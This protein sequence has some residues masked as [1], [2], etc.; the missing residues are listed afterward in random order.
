MRGLWRKL[1]HLRRHNELARRLREELDFHTDMKASESGRPVN[2][3]RR[4]VGNSARIMEQAHDV[5]S[6]PALEHVALDLRYAWRALAKSPAF[7]LLAALGTAL[8]VAA[9]TTVLS[10]AS[11][12]LF[13]AVPYRDADRLVVVSDQL[14]NLGFPRFPVTIAN[15][16]D[17]RAQ[18]RVF[19]DVAAFDSRAVT[20]VTSERAERISGMLVSSNFLSLMGGSMEQGRWIT[21]E[22]NHG[23]EDRAVVL[24]YDFW[25]SRFGGEAGVIGKRILIDD[26]SCNVVGVLKQGFRFRLSGE[27]PQAWLP[28]NLDPDPA[29]L[30]GNFRL[31]ARLARGVS[32][33][34]ASAQ[35]RVIATVLQRRYRTGMG[36]H[37]EDGGYGIA[38]VPV[39]G[40]LYGTARPTMY[41]SAIA[42]GILLLLGFANTAVLW[43]GRAS[44][45]RQEA[46]VRLALGASRWRV[47]QQ[48]VIEALMPAMTGGVLAL[49]LTLVAL[50]VLQTA[51][52]SEFSIIDQFS[53][54]YRVF[55]FT[56]LLSA[57]VGVLS[58]T[59][60]L[61]SL[62]RREAL[63]QERAGISGRG[64]ARTR[65]FLIAIQVGLACALLPPT[66][67]L[68]ESLVALE[69]VDPGFRTADVSTALVTIPASKYRTPAQI[70]GYYQRLE[71]D[72]RAR[73]GAGKIT[74]A[75]QL[76]LSFGAGGDPFSIEG[77]AFRASGAVPQFAHQIQVGDGYFSLLLSP[78]LAGRVFD[79]RD[80]SSSTDVAIVNETLARGFWPNESAVGK[81]I[82]IGAPR[83]DAK[84]MEIVG[85]VGDVH[86]TQL[87]Q[88]PLPQIYRPFP[89]APTRTMAL[90]VASGGGIGADLERI[91][92]SIDSNVPLYQ[93]KTMEQVVATSLD[94]P[95]F[96]TQLFTAYGLLAFALAAFGVHSLSIYCGIRRRREFALR[97]ALGATTLGLVGM[98]LADTMRS[99]SIGAVVGFA[100]AFSIARAL[101]AFLYGAKASD[102]GAYAIA[103]VMA[104]S[105]AALASFLGSR[106]LMK[107]DPAMVL[108]G[109]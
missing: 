59:L 82:L 42:S 6:M 58:G 30:V 102:F 44:A 99:A 81:R 98:M 8:G 36:P 28:A 104:M 9:L 48:L 55:G 70:A 52:L 25:R 37:G 10:V 66:V 49:V 96:R 40:E 21:P 24:S 33:E 100:V 18:N 103:G 61:R 109:D 23:G 1:T 3:A 14:L 12:A 51:H 95:R 7:F 89:H 32:P 4:E 68:V 105:V 27:A 65:R 90:V 79:E 57:G 85:V 29:R 94:R 93:M 43:L 22:E 71:S 41:A 34:T 54:D 86:T 62:F 87:N 106:P 108:R 11:T 2:V 92:R 74:L 46:G 19:E 69:R 84:W 77:R 16:L 76:P 72:L 20:V 38:V 67:L 78:I 88:A 83:P 56:M 5:W 45:R 97:T 31:I 63:A 107:I 75:S 47:G 15:Y 64:E 17:Y 53:V 91:V 35:M 60:P 80:F 26:V 50:R 39:R 13:H 101:S 73:L